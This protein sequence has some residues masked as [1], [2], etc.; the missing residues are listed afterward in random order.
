MLRAAVYARVSSAEQ[1]ARNTISSQLSTLPAY[2]A[3]QGWRVVATYV[4][5]GKSAK[6]GQLDRRDGLQR[7]LADA[8]AGKLD[9]VT[10]VDLDRLT[11]SEDLAERGAIYGALQ[12]AG[13]RIAVSSTGQVLDLRS[14][15]GDLL[16]ALGGVFAADE[17]RKRAERVKRGKARAVAEGR[18][19]AGPTPWGYVYDR[20]SGR[21]SVDPVLGP[22]LVEIHERI[23]GGQTCEEVARELQRRGVPRCAPSKRGVRKPGKWTRER[24]WQL[25]SSATYHTGRLVADKARRLSV[26]VPTIISEETWRSTHRQLDRYKRRGNP[27]THHPRL[28]GGLAL[29]AVCGAEIVGSQATNR[30]GEHVLYYLCSR[31]RRPGEGERC[32]LPMFRADRIDPA[33]WQWVCDLLEREGELERAMLGYDAEASDTALLDRDLEAA[34]RRLRRLGEVEAAVLDQQREGLLSPDG[35]RAELRRLARERRFAEGEIESLEQQRA[36]HVERA[37]AAQRIT[38]ALDELRAALPR[39]SYPERRRL[40]ELLV[41][42][43]GPYVL[44]LGAETIEARARLTTAAGALVELAAVS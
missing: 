13:V 29:C 37:R 40:L 5:D 43:E 25:V 42:G 12:A 36:R 17:N 32:S 31:R 39:L 7:L 23:Q 21:W 34:R 27:R 1:Q 6:A 11:R 10:V 9:L 24:V 41:P 26:A 28:I 38:S 8:A 19:P 3:A 16:A 15:L 2:C 30:R 18:K 35:V 22:L 14:Q 4:D 44:R 33:V 20:E